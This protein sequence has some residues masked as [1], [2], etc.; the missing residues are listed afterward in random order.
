M[1]RKRAAFLVVICGVIAAGSALV[2]IYRPSI[3]P[4]AKSDARLFSLDVIQR[5]AVLAA[6]GDC[7]VC[8]WRMPRLLR[9]RPIFAPATAVAPHGQSLRVRLRQHASKPSR[10]KCQ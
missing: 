5:G 9:S 6:I 8:C 4:V 3:A 2:L 10:P 1:D 7:I